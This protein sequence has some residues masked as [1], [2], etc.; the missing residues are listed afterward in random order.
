MSRLSRCLRT[1]VRWDESGDDERPYRASV[2]GENWS[3]RLND[4][5]AQPLYTLFVGAKE[6]GHVEDWPAAWKRPD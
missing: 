5:P 6:I 1:E 2:G 4:F 3:L